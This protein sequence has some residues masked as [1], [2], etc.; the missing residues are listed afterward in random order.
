MG[1]R[2]ITTLAEM[3]RPDGKP[4]RETWEWSEPPIN[5]SG[6][7]LAARV[8]ARLRASGWSKTGRSEGRKVC[9]LGAYGQELYGS[10]D[11]AIATYRFQALQQVILEQYPGKYP[12]NLVV[13]K[14]NDDPDVTWDDVEKMLEKAVAKE[15]ELGS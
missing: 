14:F 7:D 10:P 5:G 9:L 12:P 6:S 15:Q 4:E 8:L 1:P 11:A 13:P 2:R 3:I